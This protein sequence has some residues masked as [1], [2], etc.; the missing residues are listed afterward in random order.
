M[1][2][3]LILNGLRA[4]ASAGMFGIILLVFICVTYILP[5]P[6]SRFDTLFILALVTQIALIVYKYEHAKE[7]LIIGVFHLLGTCMEVFKVSIG[8]WAYPVDGFFYIQ[9]VPLF[10]GFMYA[11]VGS[12]IARG[13][14]I[15]AVQLKHAP[16]SISLF[17]MSTCIYINFFT[18]HFIYDFRYCILAGIFYMFARTKVCVTIGNR[19]TEIHFLAIASAI[20]ILIWCAEN[21]ATYAHIWRYPHQSTMWRPVH[22]EK[23]TSW[24]LLMLVSFSLVTCMLYPTLS[25][26]KKDIDS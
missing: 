7:A 24:F 16:D 14:R 19:R 10:A 25:I 15:Y 13:F 8:S 21:I 11:A 5:L 17:L 2:V 26:R 12:A 22:F 6:L 3:Q 18:H 1:T 23:I 9:N 4:T 20:A